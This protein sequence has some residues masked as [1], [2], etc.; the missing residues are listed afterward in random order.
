MGESDFKF[1][2][3]LV[4]H[5]SSEIPHWTDPKQA[6]MVTMEALQEVDD[7]GVP[8]ALP[9]LT[10]LAPTCPLSLVIYSAG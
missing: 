5:Q 10:P 8:I 3:Y 2:T 6:M 9:P 4:Q 1:L 7:D